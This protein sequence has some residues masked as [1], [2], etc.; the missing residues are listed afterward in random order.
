MDRESDI[1]EVDWLETHLPGQLA[2]SPSQLWT[3]LCA[4]SR[5]RPVTRKTPQATN[6]VKSA[7]ARG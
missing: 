6:R 5:M 3:I 1:R 2:S 4:L 7:K